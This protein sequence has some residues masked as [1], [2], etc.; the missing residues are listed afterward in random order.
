MFGLAVNKNLDDI[1]G[2]LALT[3]LRRL[4]RQLPE[5]GTAENTLTSLRSRSF[6]TAPSS[7]RARI[8]R[9]NTSLYASNCLVQGSTV[10]LVQRWV[11]PGLTRD[12]AGIWSKRILASVAF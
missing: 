1:E 3:S 4:V 12:D 9:Y 2:M 11:Y 7:S 6:A 10:V 5:Q 8:S